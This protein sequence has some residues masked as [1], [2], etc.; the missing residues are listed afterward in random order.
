[1]LL[2]IFPNLMMSSRLNQDPSL[3]NI[4][5]ARLRYNK[6]MTNPG[7]ETEDTLFEKLLDILHGQ[8]RTDTECEAVRQAFLYAREK[9]EGQFRKNRDKYIVH[10]V[11]VAIMLAEIPVGTPT[12]CAALLHDVLEDTSATS[13][14][15]KNWFGT[16]V[17]AIVEGVTKLGKF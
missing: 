2:S 5:A 1:G 11:H 7:C 3:G 4:L 14:D 9:H 12:V 10:P 16:E 13:E 6:N 17:L 8:E 15:L